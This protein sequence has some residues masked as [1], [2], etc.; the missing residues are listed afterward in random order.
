MAAEPQSTATV[1]ESKGAQSV[2]RLEPKLIGAAPYFV[3]GLVLVVI[4]PVILVMAVTGSRWLAHFGIYLFA[5]TLLLGIGA[6]IGGFKALGRKS[7]PYLEVKPDGLE[8]RTADAKTAVEKP[9]SHFERA[10][11]RKEDRHYAIFLF[12]KTR[13]RTRPEAGGVGIPHYFCSEELTPEKLC[14]RLNRT[15]RERLR[16]TIHCE[17]DTWR[18]TKCPA[19]TRSV[20]NLTLA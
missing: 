16:L 1:A 20:F 8:I 11:I 18:A 13:P 6:L 3:A 14:E 17:Q 7:K 5:L 4:S 19:R 2:Q 15:D 12:A 9:W 10:G